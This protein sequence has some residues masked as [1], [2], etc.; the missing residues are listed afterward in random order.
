M[1][2]ALSARDGPLLAS[3]MLLHF[4]ND[5]ASILAK[6]QAGAG[7]GRKATGEGTGALARQRRGRPG[8]YGAG[9]RGR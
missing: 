4:E 2:R 7:G 1:T 6:P 8:K 3:L 9:P 5:L